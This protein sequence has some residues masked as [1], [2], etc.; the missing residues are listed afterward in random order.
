MV[1]PRR[2]QAKVYSSDKEQ[3]S[4]YDL[5]DGLRLSLRANIK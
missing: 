4:H 1:S 2:T 3:T 5:L